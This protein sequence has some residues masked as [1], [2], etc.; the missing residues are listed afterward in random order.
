MNEQFSLCIETRLIMNEK[1]YGRKDVQKNQP[2]TLNSKDLQALRC[3]WT[4]LC[5]N[6][7]CDRERKEKEDSG[8]TSQRF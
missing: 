5:V 2:N 1:N 7:H 6:C 3:R 8:I 4:K